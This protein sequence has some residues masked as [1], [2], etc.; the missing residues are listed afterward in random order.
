MKPFGMTNGKFLYRVLLCGVLLAVQVFAQIPA[1]KASPLVQAIDLA[2]KQH[3][4][5]EALPLLKKLTLNVIDQQLRYR[6]QIATAHCAIKQKDGQ[7]TVTA[8]LALK[9]EYP[10]DPELQEGLGRSRNRFRQE[11]GSRYGTR[12]CLRDHDAR[13][14][15]GMV[16][17][18]Q[19]G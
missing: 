17:R 16:H 2:E 15:R 19:A 18:A 1:P 14:V 12:K 11:S 8:L 10:E 6:A 9:H 7:A 5:E 13:N 4:C 3:H